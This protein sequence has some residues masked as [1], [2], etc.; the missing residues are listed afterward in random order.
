MDYS[1]L[2][3]TTITPHASDNVGVDSSEPEDAE[4]RVFESSELRLMRHLV[5]QYD[6]SVRPV[7][8]ANDPVDIRLGL[9]LTQILDLAPFPLHNIFPGLPLQQF[10]RSSLN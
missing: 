7:F 3:T 1:P 6:N 8:D 5:G 2:S 10:A 9:T 4:E